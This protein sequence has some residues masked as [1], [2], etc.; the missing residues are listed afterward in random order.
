[1]TVY[2]LSDAAESPRKGLLV[3]A[4]FSRHLEYSRNGIYFDAIFFFEKEGK[5]GHELK[6]LTILDGSSHLGYE[7]SLEVAALSIAKAWA[8]R[9]VSEVNLGYSWKQSSDAILADL[10]AILSG[11]DCYRSAI[12][13]MKVFI[14]I[15]ANNLPIFH[16]VFQISKV[17]FGERV[18]QQY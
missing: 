2:E 8:L 6:C 1:M 9:L 12:Q 14:K 7:G 3:L 10:A 17:E 13:D 18:F 15:H 16:Q 11:Q 4:D 5:I